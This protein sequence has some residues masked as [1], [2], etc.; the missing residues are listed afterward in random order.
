MTWTSEAAEHAKRVFP[1]ESCGLLVKI[2]GEEQYWECKNISPEPEEIFIINPDDWVEAEDISDEIIAVVHSHP[3]GSADPSELDKESCERFRWPFYIFSVEKDEWHYLEPERYIACPRL[4]ESTNTDPNLRTIRLYGRLAREIGWKTLH[5][6]VTNTAS[7][8]AFL[9]ANWPNIPYPEISQYYQ[10]QIGE[11]YI[12]DK[13]LDLEVEGDI[14]IVPI[15]SGS[16]FWAAVAAIK[17]W[18]LAQNFIVQTLVMTAALTAVEY[19]V[20]TAINWL[21]PKDSNDD[22]KEQ[23][24]ASIFSGIQNVSR[25]GV[26]VPVL[27][28][29]VFTGSNVISAGVHA[30]IQN[31]NVDNPSSID[32]S[33]LEAAVTAFKE[34]YAWSKDKIHT[35]RDQSKGMAELGNRDT[36]QI[37]EIVDLWGEG[38]I[39]GFPSAASY[40]KTT[41][42][43]LYNKAALKDVYVDGAP[44]LS[45]AAVE[46]FDVPATYNVQSVKFTSRFG[47]VDQ[48]PIPE[49]NRIS[50]ATGYSDLILR[51]AGQPPSTVT[52]SIN[53][54]D[55]NEAVVQIIFPGGLRNSKNEAS[56]VTFQIVVVLNTGV[57]INAF[58]NTKYHGW[59]DGNVGDV[60]EPN[61]LNS[62]GK[63]EEGLNYRHIAYEKYSTGVL[64]LDYRIDLDSYRDLKY[65][66]SHPSYNSNSPNAVAGTHVTQIKI[67]RLGNNYTDSGAQG[68][69]QLK[70]ITEV[71]KETPNYFYSAY[72]KIT[73]N[74]D[75]FQ[76]IPRR[77]Y[78]LRGTKIK[79]PAANTA[80]VS[81]HFTRIANYRYIYIRPVGGGHGL[82]VGDF[83]TLT[84]TDTGGILEA[85]YDPDSSIG[86]AYDISQFNGIYK[87]SLNYNSDVFAIENALQVNDSDSDKPDE[88]GSGN[89]FQTNPT[90]SQQVTCTYKIT[91]GVDSTNGRIIYPNGYVFN[92]TLTTT[93]YWCSDPAWILYDLLTNTRT[94]PSSLVN[95][96]V[97]GAYDYGLGQNID[98]TVIDK[99]NLFEASK[100]A[101]EL[102]HGEPRFSC[103]AV[104]NEQKQV[105]NIIND[106]C[107]CFRAM[108]YYASGAL[109]LSVDKPGDSVYVF[110]R[111]NV[112]VDGFSYTGSPS[113]DRYTVVNVSYFNLDTKE[114]D[115]VTVEADKVFIDKYGYQVKSLK[116]FACNSKA[117]AVRLGRWFIQ[118]QHN[119]GETVTFI[120]SL[121]SGV[122]VRPGQI[123][124]ISDPLRA[125][126]RLGGRIASVTNTSTFV[127]DHLETGVSLLEDEEISVLLPTAAVTT[128]SEVP[129]GKL[130]TKTIHADTNGTSVVVKSAFSEAP[131]VGAPWVINKTDIK[132]IKYR[133]VGIGESDQLNYTITAMRYDED[134]YDVIEANVEE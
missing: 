21:A 93:K 113:E 90:S 16:W 61:I 49:N 3:K 118:T 74:S 23:E 24:T 27:Y 95:E 76:S 64:S 103:N 119:E 54:F 101:S 38:E 106:I 107:S 72:G 43:T 29:D 111:S 124:S 33:T 58:P 18:Y 60:V 81:A 115:Y 50:T 53:N 85:T 8:L 122:L 126:V 89:I 47:T 32:E 109:Q 78:H 82:S 96:K 112:G 116:S 80:S 15:V 11:E 123:I 59:I 13:L 19:G 57:A 2:D 120:S 131:A 92:G 87:V 66:S 44:V 94:I 128:G 25:S 130:E 28:G 98:E 56:G 39:E 20:Q 79:I 70:S 97:T 65:D 121:H 88:I 117:Q 6:D 36:P 5:A 110:N 46:P 30:G 31:L 1:E 127:I 52:K 125:G 114:R 108:P 77:M 12:N 102:V 69:F 62:E 67:E 45:R 132:P 63:I 40:S 35:F 84:V 75:N 100:Y 7:V 10:I 4:K 99:Y 71:I 129:Y 9:N 42:E 133:V 55:A 48:T 91:P 51:E 41:Q 105:Y 83:V 68:T 14:R 34:E 17:K 37:L 104:L 86:N 26:P 134:K 73:L 22:S